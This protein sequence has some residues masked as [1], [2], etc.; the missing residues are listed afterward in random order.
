MSTLSTKTPYLALLLSACWTGAAP[1]QQTVE[2]KPEAH[3][4]ETAKTKVIEGIVR[5]EGDRVALEQ[6]GQLVALDESFGSLWVLVFGCEAR[7]TA[8]NN[9]IER[10][11]LTGA[12]CPYREIGRI[13]EVTGTLVREIGAPGTKLAGSPMT[14]FDSDG[15]RYGVIGGAVPDPGIE[16]TVRVRKL[17]ANMAYAARD[18]D[19]DIWFEED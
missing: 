17:L 14:Y 19:R 7:A 15:M 4:M 10:L 8:R 18:T 3:A 2:P 12:D 11:E 13:E 6:N 9:R 1:V 16:V 5:F